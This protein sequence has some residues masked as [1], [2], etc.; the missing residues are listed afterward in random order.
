MP[1]R[2]VP[3]VRRRSRW[4]SQPA[5][6]G[7]LLQTQREPGHSRPRILSDRAPL[8]LPYFPRGSPPPGPALGC[9]CAF[10]SVLHQCRCRP[11]P[12]ALRVYCRHISCGVVRAWGGSAA[13]CTACMNQRASTSGEGAASRISAHPLRARGR[14]AGVALPR[15]ASPR[16][17]ADLRR[18]AVSGAPHVSR[19]CAHSVV[20]AC[21]AALFAA[22]RVPLGGASDSGLSHV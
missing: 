22:R 8:T 13:P 15:D 18:G 12:S 17:S 9:F 7:P 14:P 6:A 1:P 16:A 21:W 3:L 10:P 2:V 19:G 5:A 20:R 11:C 4:L